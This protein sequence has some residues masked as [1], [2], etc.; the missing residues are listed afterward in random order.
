M[1]TCAI[2]TA[3]DNKEARKRLA[4]LPA[5]PAKPDKEQKVEKPGSSCED[6]KGCVVYK[7][8]GYLPAPEGQAPNEKIC[9]A[10]VHSGTACRCHKSDAIHNNAPHT[11]P[12][13]TLKIWVA[14]VESDP[15][16][17]WHASVC[18]DLIQAAIGADKHAA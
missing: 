4:A 3:L 16:I 5:T 1:P 17:S 13:K 14:H 11:W 8:R 6:N 7:R 15:D 2:I 9:V 18:Q 12:I 10:F